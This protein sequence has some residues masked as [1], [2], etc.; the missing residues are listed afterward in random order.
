[1]NS[2]TL[3]GQVLGV[4]RLELCLHWL[5]SSWSPEEREGAEAHTAAV[6][7]RLKA[8]G[9]WGG[10]LP[11]LT[12]SKAMRAQR[13][14]TSTVNSCAHLCTCWE[15]SGCHSR[16]GLPDALPR[17]PALAGARLHR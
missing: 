11:A 7:G 1:M 12:F 8:W 9:G 15:D 3:P 16:A 13:P 6:G 14:Y 5:N 4:Q 17:L 10:A 2:P